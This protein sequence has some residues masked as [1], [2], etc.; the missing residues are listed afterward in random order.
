[1]PPDIQV[2]PPGDGDAVGSAAF[3]LGSWKQALSQFGSNPEQRMSGPVKAMLQDKGGQGE[4]PVAV[5]DQLHL[6]WGRFL[7][8]LSKKGLQ[9]LVSHLHASELV[10]C[11]PR[12]VVELGCC[13]KFSFEELQHDTAMLEGE[14]ASFYG[15][16]LKLVVRY[17]AARDACTKEK[18]I[19]TMF[20]EL[21]DS[22]EV[23]RCII[24]EFG[25]ELVY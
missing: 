18:S 6:E 19:F 21:S 12:G 1:M 17:D 7:D 25:G 4:A 20:Q 11:S 13:R 9:V 10:S 14:I 2:P 8:H 5:L 23:V 22:N 16:P 24:R 3:D 15:L